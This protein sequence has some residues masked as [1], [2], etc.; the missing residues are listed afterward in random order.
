MFAEESD[1]IKNGRVSDR[2][3]KP[4]EMTQ[5]TLGHVNPDYQWYWGKSFGRVFPITI[6]PI[7]W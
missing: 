1:V 4:Y 6:L 2:V 3:R 5:S 7:Q